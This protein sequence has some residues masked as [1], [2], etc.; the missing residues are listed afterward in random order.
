[1]NRL[2]KKIGAY[3][4]IV[5]IFLLASTVLRTVALFLDYNLQTGYFDSKACII[6]GNAILITGIAVGLIS[7]LLFRDEMK[8]VASFDSAVTYIPSGIVSA[9][10][11]F[12]AGGLSIKVIDRPEKLLSK[13]SLTNPEV[14]Y[15]L[16]IIAACVVAVGAFLFNA[17]SDKRADHKRGAFYVAMVIFL[18]LYSAYLYFS[19]RLPINAHVKIADQLAYMMA[20]VFFLFEARISL[21][22]PV[23][24]GY[25]AFG[26]VAALLTA[27]SSLPS[28]ILY[29]VRGDIVSDSLYESVLTFTLFIFVSARL[30]LIT[31]LRS[32][33]PC[34]CARATLAMEENRE[35]ARLQAEQ[36]R[37][38]DITNEENLES[39]EPSNYT[40]NIDGDDAATEE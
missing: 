35:A 10:L 20:A 19:V 11:L 1:M 9:A 36:T 31:E 38:C 3:Q 17:L 12:V 30:I 16:I 13:V 34:G 21:D 25:M 15:M 18:T 5:F 24:R 8:F 2:S 28:L 7:A 26:F 33:S 4:L 27:Y 32:D 29:L 6:V 39:E 37:A 23:W 40:I 14:I 22:R